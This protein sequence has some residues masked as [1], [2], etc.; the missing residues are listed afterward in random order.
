MSRVCETRAE[1]SACVMRSPK[2]VRRAG[3]GNIFNQ[4]YFKNSNVGRKF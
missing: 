4:I 2:A 3:Q 1:I